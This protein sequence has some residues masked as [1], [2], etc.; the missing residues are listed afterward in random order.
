MKA[1]YGRSMLKIWS[2]TGRLAKTLSYF[3][4]KVIRYEIR[5]VVTASGL[6]ISLSLTSWGTINQRKTMIFGRVDEM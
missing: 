4:I 3:S 1:Y 5:T 6:T 2:D